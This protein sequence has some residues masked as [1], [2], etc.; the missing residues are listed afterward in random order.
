MR[1]VFIYGPPAVGKFTV[2]RELAKRTG[3]RNF[4]NRVSIDF[5]TQIFDFETAEADYLLNLV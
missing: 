2:A 3:Y 1:L 5:A 4:H